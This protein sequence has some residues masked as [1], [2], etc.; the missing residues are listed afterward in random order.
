MFCI[1]LHLLPHLHWVSY[2]L[3]WCWGWPYELFWPINVSRSFGCACTV[4]LDLSAFCVPTACLHEGELAPGAI[5]PST[6]VLQWQIH[7]AYL[8]LTCSSEQGCHS[9]P[10]NLRTRYKCCYLNHWEFL[11]HIKSWLIYLAKFSKELRNGSRWD[12]SLI[13]V[14]GRQLIWA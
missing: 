14:G 5:M 3:H 11:V 10:A 13:K 9:C 4:W 8:N 7:A 12:L 6:W 2:P 1:P